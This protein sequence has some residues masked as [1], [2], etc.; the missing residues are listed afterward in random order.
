MRDN[1]IDKD[2]QPCLERLQL[3]KPLRTSSS[4][5]GRKGNTNRR[6][7]HDTRSVICT[8]KTGMLHN[9]P[10]V[11]LVSRCRLSCHWPCPIA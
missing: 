6:A 9:A 4:N 1:Q 7:F 11:Y 10:L 5:E 8:E 3:A 2:S